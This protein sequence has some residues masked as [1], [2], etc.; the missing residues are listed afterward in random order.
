MNSYLEIFFW[1]VSLGLIAMSI[2]HFIK[3]L[4]A[5]KND[6]TDTNIAKAT[7]YIAGALTLM[8]LLVFKPFG[9]TK[10][11]ASKIFRPKTAVSAAETVM[12]STSMSGPTT[13]VS[14]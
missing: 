8:A 6:K 5:D 14:V 2:V 4:K 9:N 13:A 7:V 3:V 11:L 10:M 12:I 1:T